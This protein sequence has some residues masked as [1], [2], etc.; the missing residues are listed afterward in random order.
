MRHFHRRKLFGVSLMFML[1]VSAVASASALAVAYFIEGNEV[2]GAEIE[3]I[4]SRELSTLFT[5][6]VNNETLY[7][8]CEKS[9]FNLT[10]EKNGEA[11]GTVVFETEPLNRRG[12]EP[13][14]V[15]P[16]TRNLEPLPN[17]T[18][19]TP[20]TWP[21]KGQLIKTGALEA[22]QELKIERA[23]NIELVGARCELPAGRV[24]SGVAYPV[25]GEVLCALVFASSEQ[26]RHELTCTTCSS[27]I[28]FNRLPGTLS[29]SSEVIELTGG[30]R[31]SAR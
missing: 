7:V 8:K 26:V 4:R 9:P 21:V 3:T 5:G 15:N 1:A 22:E 30:R 16:R 12:C 27:K 20:F 19:R 28:R 13:G 29:I 11:R 2:R 10:I 17:C 25:E 24:I 23:F 6:T 14:T 18:V 31:W